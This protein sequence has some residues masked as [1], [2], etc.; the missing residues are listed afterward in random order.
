M[1]RYIIHNWKDVIDHQYEYE[2]NERIKE[3]MDY[4]SESYKKV[5]FVYANSAVEV[6]SEDKN[7]VYRFNGETDMFEYVHNITGSV[8]TAHYPFTLQE[9]NNL[10]QLI[11]SER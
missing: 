5:S 4:V 7:K 2:C 1:K 3:I 11:K 9:W 10:N 6:I 8:F